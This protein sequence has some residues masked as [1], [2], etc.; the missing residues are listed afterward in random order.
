[1]P[2]DRVKGDKRKFR[3]RRSFRRTMFNWTVK[4]LSITFLI[5][6]VATSVFVFVSPRR[7]AT[8]SPIAQLKNQIKQYGPKPEYLK[9]LAR[10][11]SDEGQI[12]EA[13]KL[14]RQVLRDNPHDVD[15]LAYLIQ[16]ERDIYPED[17]AEH[18]KAYIDILEA[19]LAEESSGS[20]TGEDSEG[21]VEDT[22]KLLYSRLFELKL[23][24]T[25]T[26][27]SLARYDEALKVLDE[28]QASYGDNSKVRYAREMVLLLAGKYNQLKEY[29][30]SIPTG[31]RR[32]DEWVTLIE[33]K[34]R[35]NED[36]SELM[37]EVKALYPHRREDLTRRVAAIYISVGKY[38]EA[39]SL[40]VS[41]IKMGNASYEDYISLGMIYYAQGDKDEAERYFKKAK[42]MIPDETSRQAIELSIEAFKRRIEAKA[43]KKQEGER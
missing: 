36:V 8:V 34:I 3:T 25:L 9:A 29:I 37:D 35:L 15:A 30:N 17:Y 41:L 31:K 12:V 4:V 5:I 26:L 13:I 27:A 40:L 28:L 20:E 6:F 39:K 11:Y 32:F 43:D 42:Q 7:G 2:K 21:K 22:V 16:L 38:V 10:L 1:M 33:A 18:L 19:K 24:Y 14:Y 23:N